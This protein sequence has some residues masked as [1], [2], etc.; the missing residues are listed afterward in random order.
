MSNK[1]TEPT[2]LAEFDHAGNSFRVV[3]A[4]GSDEEAAGQ[5]YAACEATEPVLE[6]LL[7]K[8][9]LGRLVWM[10]TTDAFAEPDGLF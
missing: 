1:N 8:N 4:C 2:V 10:I 6:V 7:Y 3:V 5:S 9:T